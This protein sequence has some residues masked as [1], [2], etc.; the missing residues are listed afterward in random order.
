MPRERRKMRKYTVELTGH[1]R[2][3]AVVDEE[4]REFLVV[5][6]YDENSQSSNWEVMDEQGKCVG[7]EGRGELIE[8]VEAYI[9]KER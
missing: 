3:F 9:R 5:Q 7:E 1:T 8:V 4:D 2:Y 6:F